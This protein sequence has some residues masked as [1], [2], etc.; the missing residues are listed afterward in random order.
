MYPRK[1]LIGLMRACSGGAGSRTPVRRED[2]QNVSIRSEPFGFMCG[3]SG[4][5]D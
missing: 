1:A 5:L 4:T 3:N 2:P